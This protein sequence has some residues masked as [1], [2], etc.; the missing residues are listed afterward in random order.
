MHT[1]FEGLMKYIYTPTFTRLTDDMIKDKPMFKSQFN[2]FLKQFEQNEPVVMPPNAKWDD[3]Q[4]LTRFVFFIS[5]D[6]T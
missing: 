1:E 6:W 3:P 5:R 4:E 2:W